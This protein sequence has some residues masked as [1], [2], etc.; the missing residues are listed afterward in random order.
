MNI[1]ENLNIENVLALESLLEK[2]KKHHK[3]LAAKEFADMLEIDRKARMEKPRDGS[4]DME[5]YYEGYDQAMADIRKL[6]QS[7]KP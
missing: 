4:K 5:R 2:Y 7:Y 3:F 6:I 1:F